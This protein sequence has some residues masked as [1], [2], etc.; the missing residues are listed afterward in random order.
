ME[1]PLPPLPQ[2]LAAPSPPETGRL[3][4]RLII[5]LLVYNQLY[6]YIYI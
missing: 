1:K 4:S 6:I 3:A 2:A 5:A